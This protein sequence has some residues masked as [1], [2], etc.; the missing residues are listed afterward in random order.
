MPAVARDSEKP[1]PISASGDV[2]RPT[3]AAA[4][5]D[6]EQVTGR[7][8]RGA[9]V[10][11]RRPPTSTRLAF[12]SNASVSDRGV[13]PSAGTTAMRELAWKKSGRPIADPNA[14]ALPSGDHRGP[15]SGPGWVTIA[16]TLSSASVST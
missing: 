4:R 7:L 2:T 5:I 14:M 10:D 13:P 6:A 12:S 16:L 1:N 3:A 15:L 11:R 9:E 8:L